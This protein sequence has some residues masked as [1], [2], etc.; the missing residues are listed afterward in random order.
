MEILS[1]ALQR[2]LKSFYETDRHANE[3]IVLSLFKLL[4]GTSF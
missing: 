1:P 4:L 3:V 2:Q